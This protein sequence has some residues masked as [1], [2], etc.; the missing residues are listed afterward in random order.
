MVIVF[1]DENVSY[2]PVGQ[3]T[4]REVFEYKRE[5]LKYDTL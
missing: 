3:E 2:F 5:I 4:V 1:I